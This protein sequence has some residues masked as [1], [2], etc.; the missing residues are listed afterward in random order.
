[1]RESSMLKFSYMAMLLFT[2]VGSFWLEIFLH[3]RVLRKIRL[4]VS[5]IFPVAVVFIVWD[6][7]AIA[8]HHWHFDVKQIVGLYGPFHIPI[9]EYLFFLIIPIAAI[10]TYEAV[11]SVKKNWI[12]DRKKTS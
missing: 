8:Q 1:M 7:Y 2:I 3:I 11:L 5:S 4:L 9:E 6:A 12:Q 10:L